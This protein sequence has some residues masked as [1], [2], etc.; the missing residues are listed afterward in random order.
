MPRLTPTILRRTLSNMIAIVNTET[1]FQDIW[2][3]T[4]NIVVKNSCGVLV[5]ISK[6]AAIKG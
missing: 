6:N 5:G 1:Y 3:V 4:K 2:Y